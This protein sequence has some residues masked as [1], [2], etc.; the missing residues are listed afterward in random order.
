V[1]DTETWTHPGE[2]AHA[3]F[4]LLA[5]STLRAKMTMSKKLDFIPIRLNNDTNFACLSFFCF[6]N[7]VELAENGMG[8]DSVWGMFEVSD[9]F[10]CHEADVQISLFSSKPWRLILILI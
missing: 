2:V 4:K 5:N 8:L 7:P 9:I 6:T 3:I 10:P 1:Y